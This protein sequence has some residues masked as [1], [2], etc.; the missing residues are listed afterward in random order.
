MI[1]LFYSH[2][3]LNPVQRHRLTLKLHWLKWWETE[4]VETTEK[5]QH[6]NCCQVIL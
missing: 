2:L 1:P 5:V 3:Y 4:Q 6:H